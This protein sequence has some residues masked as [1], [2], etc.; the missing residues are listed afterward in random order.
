MKLTGYLIAA[1]IIVSG[2]AYTF[3]YLNKKHKAA[4]ERWS[5]NFIEVQKD[6]NQIEFTV[7]EFQRNIDKRTDSI[8]K[9]A[10]VKPKHVTQ[11]TNYNTIYKDTTIT[12]LVLDYN[13]ITGTY[14]FTDKTACFEFSGFIE[15]N[16]TV[17]DLN[18]TERKF[19]SDF[20]DI[21][22]YEK[23]T[24]HFLGLNLVKWWQKKRLT[25]TII[26]KCTG[27]KIVKKFNVK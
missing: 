4:A 13:P 17:P 26:D 19:Y 22:H 9:L 14:P 16:D 8:L 3:Y 12:E 10:N 5:N 11:V 21:E 2:L 25:Y 20:Y 15:V 6:I 7:R 18:V 23:D 27:E 24:I 1:L